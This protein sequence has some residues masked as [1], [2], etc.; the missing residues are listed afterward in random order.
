MKTL[1]PR[2]RVLRALNHQEVDRVPIDLGGTQNSTIG[3]GAYNALKD[4]LGVD[5]PTVV[6]NRAFDI[7]RM[8]ERL[9]TR[10]PVDTRSVFANPPAHTQSR[11]LDDRTLIDDW[12]VTYRQPEGWHQWDMVAHPL[13]E[14]T[15][16][17]LESYPWP[18]VDDPARYAGLA[19]L[20]RDLHENT[21]Y[22]VC[23]STMDT[24][25]FDRA[26]ELRGMQ[27]FLEDLL[28]DPEFALAL[29]EKV[30]DLQYRRHICFLREVGKYI[31]VLM[32]SDDM[33]VQRGPLLRPQLYRKMIKP[34]HARYVQM[35]RQ[36]TGAKIVNHACGSI[37]D[38]IEDYIEIGID[39]CNPMQVSAVGMTPQNL[40]TRFGGRMAFWG[41][42]D[43]QHV[44]P[45]GSPDDVRQ[46]VRSTLDVMGLEGGYVL[47][48]VHNVQDDVPPANVWA[49]LDE[50]A[51]YQPSAH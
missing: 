49:M 29:L 1:Q 44:L 41:G 26:W 32:I 42:I 24:T 11:W 27:Q 36:H 21:P 4:Y 23:A 6:I 39:A 14:A 46:A 12:G 7:V 19:D 45:Q 50:A 2:E 43:T 3:T 13:A 10:L 31:D 37:V 5:A 15:I 47:G 22:A 30:A 35:I 9:L 16:D 8:D 34:F 28:A 38:V 17:D 33:G 48:A 40:K 51:T 18:D 20:A 25:I